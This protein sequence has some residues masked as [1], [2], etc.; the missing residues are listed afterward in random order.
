MIG[1]EGGNNVN[2]G[3]PPPPSWGQTS[4][5]FPSQLSIAIFLLKYCIIADSRK[6]NYEIR[7]G[8]TS[9]FVIHCLRKIS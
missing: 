8:L 5:M 3:N 4:Y 6:Q 1:M 2:A 7:L 9:S